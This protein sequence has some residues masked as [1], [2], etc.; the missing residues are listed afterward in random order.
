VKDLLKEHYASIKA[1]E[2]RAD[3]ETLYAIIDRLL[4]RIEELEVLLEKK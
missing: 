3:V 1:R 4:L 2:Q